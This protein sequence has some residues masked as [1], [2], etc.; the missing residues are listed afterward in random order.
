[1]YEHYNNKNFEKLAKIGRNSLCLCGSNLKYKNCCAL[2]RRI[3]DG[4][5]RVQ[6]SNDVLVNVLHAAKDYPCLLCG[7]KPNSV[8]LFYPTEE[9]AKKIGQPKNKLRIVAYSL[10][11]KCR[12]IKDSIK[13]V[14]E[15]IL[16]DYIRGWDTN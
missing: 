14:E 4:Q 10:C 5:N 3:T 12:N 8:A 2:K 13:K 11:E 9:F 6:N 1:M 7:E 15:V 16:N